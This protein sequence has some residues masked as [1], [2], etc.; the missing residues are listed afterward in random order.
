MEVT[1]AC[2]QTAGV[3]SGLLANVSADQLGAPTPCAEWDVKGLTDHM[4]GGANMFAGMFGGE[5]GAAPEGAV[6]GPA[7][8]AAYDEATGRLAAAASAEGALDKT[9]S[10]GRMQL[11]GSAALALAT[12]DHLTHAWDLARATGQTLEVPEELA[13]FALTSWQQM[14]QP[15]M[16]DGT[17]FGVEQQAGAGASTMDRV[18]AFTGRTV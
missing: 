3:V 12:A 4:I 16:R 2:Q 13:D 7:L 14:I 6:A 11:P 1:A 9:V 5:S 10:L 18:A 15:P 17:M 8:A